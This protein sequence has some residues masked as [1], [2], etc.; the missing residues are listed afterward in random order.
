M[1][2]FL[3][4]VSV[5][6]CVASVLAPLLAVMVIVNA[7]DAVGVPAMVAVPFPLS[8]NVTP[9]GSEPVLVIVVLAGKPGVVVTVKVPAVPSRKVGWS[10]LVITGD[11]LAGDTVS[12]NAWSLEPAALVAVIVSG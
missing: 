6:D 9:V 2:G 7:P 8:V 3:V 5:K 10:A 4:T 11:A 12:V 1:V